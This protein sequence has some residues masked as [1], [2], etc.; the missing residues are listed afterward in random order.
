MR[1][2]A[3]AFAA[4]FAAVPAQAEVVSASPNGFHLRQSLSLKVPP[5]R[6]YAAFANIGRW[7]GADHTYSGKAANLSLSLTPGSCFCER[8]DN[9]GGI[10]HLRVT[11]ADPGKRAVLTGALGPLLYQAVAG[12]MDLQFKPSGAGTELVMDYRVAGFAAGG[13]DKLAPLVDK[14]L[15][16][17]FGRYAAFAQRPPA[18][19]RVRA[20]RS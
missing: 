16:E 18:R 19:R 5:A 6:A 8:L 11:Y 3:A 7:W 2:I 15:A 9:G 12:A 4:A 10:E 14:V 20:S 1:I 13:A 17:Q